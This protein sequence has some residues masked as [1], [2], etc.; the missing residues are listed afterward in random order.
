MPTYISRRSSWMRV[1][2]FSAARAGSPT[3]SSLPRCGSRP[4]STPARYVGILQ[5]LRG[6]QRGHLHRVGF[7]FLAALQHG[8]QRHML[9]QVEERHIVFLG[10]A[11]S[12]PVSSSTFCQRV[13]AGFSSN[14]SNRCRS[15]WMACSRSSR[16]G[17]AGS[18]GASRLPSAAPRRAPL[19]AADEFGE[20]AQRFDLARRQQAFQA[21]LGHG[22]QQRQLAAGGVL[23]QRL[24]GGLADA[25]LGVVA[26]RMKAGSSSSLASSRK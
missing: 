7:F 8:H 21:G 14:S 18:A 19:H 10:L 25:A 2:R 6:M 17:P 16:I 23:A 1:A 26:A 9:H 11:P 20:G 4:S 3:S 22:G 12:Q 24:Q 5:P 15:Y 13:C